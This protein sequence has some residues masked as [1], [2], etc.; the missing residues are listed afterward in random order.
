MHTL[1]NIILYDAEYVIKDY[2]PKP[3]IDDI[4][5]SGDRKTFSF[6]RALFFYAIIINDILMWSCGIAILL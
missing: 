3:I 6:P 2:L 5:L 4:P 1:Y